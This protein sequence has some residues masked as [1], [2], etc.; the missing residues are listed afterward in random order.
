MCCI[1]LLA[2]KVRWHFWRIHIA[3]SFFFVVSKLEWQKN[4]FDM[5]F[6]TSTGNIASGS[7]RNI[8]SVFG[9]DVSKMV[10]EV[11]E[12]W[13]LLEGWRAYRTALGRFG[14]EV[15]KTCGK[16]TCMNYCQNNSNIARL[17]AFHYALV[18]FELRLW[19]KSLS[20][21]KCVYNKR[22]SSVTSESWR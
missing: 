17:C 15:L 13:L 22:M 11:S 6:F 5:L 20:E 9:K 18:T 21:T 1:V 2:V 19:T 10:W 16:F 14:T 7:A 3:P 12:R 8:R 4:I